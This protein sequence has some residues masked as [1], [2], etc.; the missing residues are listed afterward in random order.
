MASAPVTNIAF[1]GFVAAA[2]LLP[3]A[4]ESFN[5][6]RLLRIFLGLSVFA[7]AILMV[8][9]DVHVYV[10]ATYGIPMAIGLILVAMAGALRLVFRGFR[11]LAAGSGN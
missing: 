3:W 6:N 2:F 4:C 5:A 11:Q 10:P 1:P 9:L 8:W 7:G